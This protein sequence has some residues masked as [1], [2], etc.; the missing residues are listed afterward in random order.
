MRLLNAFLACLLIFAAVPA[1][2]QESPFAHREIAFDADRYE[3]YI[4]AN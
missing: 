3:T 2:A 4:R 1:L